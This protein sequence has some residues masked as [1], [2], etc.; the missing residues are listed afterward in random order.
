MFRWASLNKRRLRWGSGDAGAWLTLRWARRTGFFSMIHVCGKK[1][2]YL[3]SCILF[4]LTVRRHHRPFMGS[5]WQ[6]DGVWLVVADAGKLWHPGLFCIL[7]LSKVQS[8]PRLF[9]PR[10]ARRWYFIVCTGFKPVAPKCLANQSQWPPT[11]QALQL[12]NRAAC[13]RHIANHRVFPW[14]GR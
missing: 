12:Q 3:V 4:S 7:M 5:G 9:F 14:S 6:M 10:W 2:T 1:K 11:S 8:E 13:R